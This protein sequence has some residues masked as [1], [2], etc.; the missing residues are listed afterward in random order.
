MPKMVAT[1]K[2][3]LKTL[4]SFCND[5]LRYKGSHMLVMVPNSELL[6][7]L[8]HPNMD[9]SWSMHEAHTL[10]TSLSNTLYFC[11]VDVIEDP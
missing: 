11:F 7:F 6:C 10:F 1:E 4:D 8:G 5:F 3:G 9:A 2:L